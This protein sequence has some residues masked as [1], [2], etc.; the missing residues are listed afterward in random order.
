V[1]FNGAGG[2]VAAGK[3]NDGPP[4]MRPVLAERL[5]DGMQRAFENTGKIPITSGDVAWNVT[6]VSL[7]VAAHLTR[8]SLGATLADENA[9]PAD[10]AS[11]ARKLAFVKR[12][13]AGTPI[14]IS[15]LKLGDVRLLH[16]PGELFVEY[17]LAAQA[18]LPGAHVC[19]AAYGDY[20]PGYIGTAIAYSQGGYET[21]P[22]A[23]NVAPA[24]EGVLTESIK[25]ALLVT[26]EQRS[27]E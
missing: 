12:M 10:R 8:E 2:N 15:C 25:Q 13:A 4:E 6:Q 22:T 16:L 5:A 1:H 14:D 21:G 20:S 27:P 9:K 11:A 7:P 17:Q 23:S 3:Y 24:V 19:V 26:P 18:L